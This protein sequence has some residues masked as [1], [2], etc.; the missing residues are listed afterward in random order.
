MPFYISLHKRPPSSRLKK[1]SDLSDPLIRA[2]DR[3]P[4]K[5]LSIVIPRRPI[6]AQVPKMEQ[7]EQV[8]YS[9][10]ETWTKR[11]DHG[12]ATAASYWGKCDSYLSNDAKPRGHPPPVGGEI[13]L[14]R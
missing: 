12:L 9:L 14:G 7:A 11:F 3:S 6:R 8:L 10:T 1:G 4:G 13:I 2:D 5:R